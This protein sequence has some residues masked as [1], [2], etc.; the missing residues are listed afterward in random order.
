M[1]AAVVTVCCYRMCGTADVEL[2]NKEAV[3]NCQET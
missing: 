2:G 3:H 1:L